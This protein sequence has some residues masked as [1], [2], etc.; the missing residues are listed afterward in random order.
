MASKVKAPAG[1]WDKYVSDLVRYVEEHPG[2][3]ARNKNLDELKSRRFGLKEPHVPKEFKDKVSGS[4]KSPFI[5]DI[6][7]RAPGLTSTTLPVPKVIPLEVGQ[8]AQENSSKRENWLKYAYELMDKQGSTYLKIMDALAANGLTC[9]KAILDKHTWA[10]PERGES[11]SSDDYLARVKGHKR[12]HFPFVWEHVPTETCYPRYDEKGLSY[13]LQI[14]K[15]SARRL[16]YKYGLSRGQDGKWTR[17]RTA[18]DA[19]NWT[20]DEAKFVEYWDRNVF[21]YMVDDFVVKVG[22]HGYGEVPYFFA[23]LTVT[24]ASEIEYQH[25]GLAHPLMSLQDNFDEFVS[26]LRT[27]TESQ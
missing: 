24:S 17:K 5:F 13:V 6:L 27:I 2:F 11:E 1:G 7:R 4:F 15:D 19:E 9:W 3:T 16:A 8:K 12:S 10:A 18:Y 22:E 14:T 21:V 25:F 20:N 26:M 23:A